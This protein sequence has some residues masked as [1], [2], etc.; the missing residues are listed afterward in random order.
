M[1]TIALRGLMGR[2]ADVEA[3]VDKQATFLLFHTS[4][5]QEHRALK[6]LRCR[7]LYYLIIRHPTGPLITF[8]I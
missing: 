5:H 6:G 4:L 2:M 8:L 3:V 1:T 7:H